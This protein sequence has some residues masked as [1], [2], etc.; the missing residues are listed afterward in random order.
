M[1]TA[2]RTAPGEVEGRPR[3]LSLFLS[4]L[5]M[6]GLGILQDTAAANVATRS[7]GV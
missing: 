6:R 5:G 4:R 1:P 3:E 2:S 7:S